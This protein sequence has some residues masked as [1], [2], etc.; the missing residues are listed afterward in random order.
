MCRKK[1]QSTN[2]QHLDI[3]LKQKGH[4]FSSPTFVKNKMAGTTPSSDGG[5]ADASKGGTLG[6]TETI[7]VIA[8]SD[9]DDGEQRMQQGESPPQPPKDKE[10]SASSVG[11]KKRS[12]NDLFDT[13]YSTNNSAKETQAKRRKEVLQETDFDKERLTVP[14]FYLRPTARQYRKIEARNKQSHFTSDEE[15]VKSTLELNKDKIE[16]QYEKGTLG[17]TSVVVSSSVV[18]PDHSLRWIAQ[19]IDQYRINPKLLRYFRSSFCAWYDEDGKKTYKHSS[20]DKAEVLKDAQKWLERDGFPNADCCATA[21]WS[22]IQLHESCDRLVE[23]ADNNPKLLKAMSTQAASVKSGLL[24]RVL[25]VYGFGA[26]HEKQGNGSLQ[27]ELKKAR[28]GHRGT[29]IRAI[30]KLIALLFG[31]VPQMECHLHVLLAHSTKEKTMLEKK[32]VYD[33]KELKSRNMSSTAVQKIVVE[34][35]PIQYFE[36][37]DSILKGFGNYFLRNSG[38]ETARSRWITSDADFVIALPTAATTHNTVPTP[39]E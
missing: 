24:P 28:E 25:M 35:M 23:L 29:A 5:V 39:K 1:E 12:R 11:K 21:L 9:D 38:G 8:D 26:H 7:Y 10:A 17:P 18:E 6:E 34:Y 4:I 27:E 20:D 37:A 2:H 14:H 3:A 30:C 15:T 22:A 31:M 36:V 32:G 19:E 13:G 33:L 16:D